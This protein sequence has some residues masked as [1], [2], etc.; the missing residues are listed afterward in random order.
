MVGLK[1][2]YD[3]MEGGIS[4]VPSI[5]DSLS[6]AEGEF[7][8]MSHQR[9][10]S[11]GIHKL[12]K[13]LTVI[14]VFVKWINVKFLRLYNISAVNHLKFFLEFFTF[15]LFA[16]LIS[17]AMPHERESPHP[18]HIRGSISQGPNEFGDMKI[19][20]LTD[21]MYQECGWC[22]ST[23]FLL[24]SL[25][26]IPREDYLRREVKQMKREGSPSP[27]GSDPLKSRSHE[28]LVTTVKEAGRS[29]HLIPPEGVMMSKPKEGSITQ[30][31]WIFV[32][33]CVVNIFSLNVH[34]FSAL[35]LR[36]NLQIGFNVVMLWYCSRYS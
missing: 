34:T 13:S 36:E 11:Q 33:T 26:G 14:K 27:R 22:L 18:H 25:S 2:S 1:R 8:L 6:A 19:I 28:V 5:R 24:S 29:I 4:R 17:R 9:L 12:I 35:I 10:D 20:V 15:P 7:D 32:F 21:H 31:T 3:M 30:V 16:G 23:T